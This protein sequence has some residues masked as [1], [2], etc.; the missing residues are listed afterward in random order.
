M[1]SV[2]E[3]QREKCSGSIERE[4]IPIEIGGD[5]T[6]EMLISLSPE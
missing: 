2:L 6:K 3:E 4:L 5:F 1:R